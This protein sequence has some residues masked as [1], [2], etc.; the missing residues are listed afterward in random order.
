MSK[1]DSSHILGGESTDIS[2]L[3]IQT[4][5]PLLCYNLGLLIIL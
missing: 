3:L 1:L 2:S 5:N 4:Q